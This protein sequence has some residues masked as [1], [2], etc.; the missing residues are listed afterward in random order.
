M[1]NGS[2]TRC[3]DK[4]G[5]LPSCA[6]LATGYVP[7]QQKTPQRYDQC[8][9]LSNGTLFPGLNL[10]FHLAVPG[11]KLPAGN[12]A[13][14][15]ALCFVVAELGLY[16]DTHPDDAEAFALFKQFA[17]MAKDAKAAVEKDNGPLMQKNTANFDSYHSWLKDP[18]PWNYEENEVK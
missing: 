14:L 9:A 18:W 7:F 3:S 8:D 15:Q 5:T 10:P 2:T 12:R 1:E 6:P 11:S 4:S 16:L 17:Q 13:D